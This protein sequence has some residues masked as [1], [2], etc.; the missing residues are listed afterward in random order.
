M[1]CLQCGRILG[2][3][4][5]KFCSN[6]CQADYRYKIAKENWL[7]GRVRLDTVNV[8]RYIRRFLLEHHGEKCV[9]CGWNKRHL[10]TKRV[11]LEVEHV[12]GDAS[13]NDIKN[14]KLLCP[15]CHS[16]TASFRNLN[17]GK[18]RAWRKKIL[19]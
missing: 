12:D 17:K 1:T 4:Q 2:K 11:P 19:N 14:L 13:N 8:S 9:E 15:N 3:A 5:K 7:S 16:L 6:Q 18:G 10:I